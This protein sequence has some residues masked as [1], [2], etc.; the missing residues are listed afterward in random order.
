M[1]AGTKHACELRQGG[2]G[3]FPVEY[4]LTPLSGDSGF[5]FLNKEASSERHPKDP[6]QI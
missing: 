2:W 5:S 3:G 4:Y 6:A 1:N